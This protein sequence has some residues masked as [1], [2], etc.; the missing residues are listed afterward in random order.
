[1]FWIVLKILLR[2]VLD[3]TRYLLKLREIIEGES[4][5]IVP[6]WACSGYERKKRFYLF[7]CHSCF[8]NVIVDALMLA[9]PVVLVELCWC[10]AITMHKYICSIARPAGT[11]YAATWETAYSIYQEKLKM[12]NAARTWTYDPVLTDKKQVYTNT[13]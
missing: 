3:K 7:F 11:F 4:D 6:M 8:I 12:K 1:M 10:D 2:I 9:C 5:K 13:R